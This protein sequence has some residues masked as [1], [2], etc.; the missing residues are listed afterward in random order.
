MCV[1]VCGDTRRQRED[2]LGN[3]AETEGVVQM[4]NIACKS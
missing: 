3:E 1:C 2:F 4:R